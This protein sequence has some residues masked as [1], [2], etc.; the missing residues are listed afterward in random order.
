MSFSIDR[1]VFAPRSPTGRDWLPLEII[2][3]GIVSMSGVDKSTPFT[4]PFWRLYR[5]LDPGG[6]VVHEGKTV[7]QLDPGRL[8][9]LP[10]W[11]T[12]RVRHPVA[13]VRH[14]FLLVDAPTLSASQVRRHF[15]GTQVFAEKEMRV[16]AADFAAIAAEMETRRGLSAAGSCRAQAVCARI[17]QKMM[18]GPGADLTVLPEPLPAAIQVIEE[19]LSGD[20]RVP[21][22]AHAVG[23]NAVALNRTFRAVLHTSPAAY[24]RERRVSRAAELL[25]GSQWSIERIAAAC[26]FPNRNYLTRVFT[27][28]LGIPPATYRLRRRQWS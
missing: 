8:V 20:C 9:V 24:V 28:H 2:Q 26:G 22:L 23:T 11:Q 7:T 13:G 4:D 3:V 1:C 12:W 18:E 15:S 16:E 27:Q 5:N 10:P 19:R 21:E 25:G 14:I 17:F 6:S